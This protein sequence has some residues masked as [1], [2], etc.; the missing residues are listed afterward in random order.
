[1]LAG[2]RARRDLHPPMQRMLLTLTLVECEVLELPETMDLVERVVAAHEASA[3]EH[4]RHRVLPRLTLQLGQYALATVGVEL[5]VS[6][7]DPLR[8]E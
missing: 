1:M 3:H 6:V 8:L 2:M 5:E 7:L 4:E